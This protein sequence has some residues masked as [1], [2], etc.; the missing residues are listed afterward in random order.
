MIT[1]VWVWHAC[2]RLSVSMIHWSHGA[3]LTGISRLPK[4]P[5][6]LTWLYVWFFHLPHHFKIVTKTFTTLLWPSLHTFSAIIKFSLGSHFPGCH[7]Q[8]SASP[9]LH[10][11]SQRKMATTWS[12]LPKK[13]KEHSKFYNFTFYT[14]SAWAIMIYLPFASTISPLLQDTHIPS[15]S[16]TLNDLNVF[17]PALFFRYLY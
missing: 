13:E 17:I 2:D 15:V 1:W 11:Q 7:H 4:V 6:A 3:S 9:A 10:C 5:D 12:Q 14:Y 8:S 16:S